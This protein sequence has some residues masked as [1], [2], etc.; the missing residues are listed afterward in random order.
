MFLVKSWLAAW[1]FSTAR[2]WVRDSMM[3]FMLPLLQALSRQLV[4]GGA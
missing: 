4:S 2:A 1:A 3:D